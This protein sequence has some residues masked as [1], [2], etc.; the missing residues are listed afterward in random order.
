MLGANPLVRDDVRVLL[1]SMGYHCVVA[2][3]LE[4]ALE[5][6][7]REQPDAAILDPHFPDSPPSRLWNMATTRAGGESG[8]C[9]SR[10]AASG[11]S[12]SGNSRACS[13]VAATTQW[14][15]MLR[16]KTRTS[17][18]TSGL[19]PSISTLRRIRG[20]STDTYLLRIEIFRGIP[21]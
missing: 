16:S 6:P 8:K 13:S 4:H 11:C 21:R 1:R 7:E 20:V 19:A 17:S 2:A 5:L 14:Y 10:M 15:P 3:T 18:R 12:R 9:G